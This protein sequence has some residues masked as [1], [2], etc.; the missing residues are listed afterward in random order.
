MHSHAELKEMKVRE[1]QKKEREKVNAVKRKLQFEQSQR[2][3]EEKKNEKEHK[4][5]RE[6]RKQTTPRKCQVEVVSLF[7]SDKEPAA[8]KGRIYLFIYTYL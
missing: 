3:E 5:E 4:I 2:E 1:R 7:S 6:G 8:K